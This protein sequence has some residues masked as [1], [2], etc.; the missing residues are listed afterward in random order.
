MADSIIELVYRTYYETVFRYCRMRLN[1]DLHAAEDCTQ[2]VFL[3]LQKKIH[4]LVDMESILPWLYATADREIKR[5]RR[6]NPET[7][8]IDEIPEPA[9][10][11]QTE[12]PLDVLD[13][14][15][16]WLVEQYFGGADKFAL[17]GQLGISLAALY[18]RV[19]RIKRKIQENMDDIHK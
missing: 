11:S 14:E 5:Y 13:E 7:V 3:V 2:E 12:S 9:A 6:K 17:A 15:E 19:Q 8:D 1:G 18:K 16:R 10:P 4:K